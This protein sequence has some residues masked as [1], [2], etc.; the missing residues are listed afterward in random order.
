MSVCADGKPENSTP[1][2]GV[3]NNVV[4]LAGTISIKLPM[5][6]I[7]NNFAPARLCVSEYTGWAWV[8]SI[9]TSIR[10]RIQTMSVIGCVVQ[11]KAKLSHTLSNKEVVLSIT[12]LDKPVPNKSGAEDENESAMAH[13]SNDKTKSG[14]FFSTECAKPDLNSAVVYYATIVQLL[15]MNDRTHEGA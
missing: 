5:K 6:R 1:T 14:G 8:E 12:A 10:V 7:R 13:L 11:M 15:I 3:R 2:L 9:I 4:L